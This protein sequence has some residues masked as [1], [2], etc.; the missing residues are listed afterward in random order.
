MN[1][2][3]FSVFLCIILILG[4]IVSIGAEGNFTNH[5]SE[6]NPVNSS[7]QE[8]DQDHSE[9]IQENSQRINEDVKYIQLE[10][11]IEENIS[12]NF[13]KS[14]S[15]PPK[16]NS[17]VLKENESQKTGQEVKEES[18]ESSNESLNYSLNE[19]NISGQK[20]A[21][22]FSSTSVEEIS[23]IHS[24][25]RGN[26]QKEAGADSSSASVSSSFEEDYVSLEGIETK[27]PTKTLSGEN[28]T[29]EKT[30]YNYYNEGKKVIEIETY[31]RVDIQKQEIEKSESEKQIIISSEEHIDDPLRIYVDLS[32]EAKKEEIEIY[33][34]NEGNLEI[35]SQE[36]FKVEYYD[37]D[38]NGLID[39]I[40]WI[41]PHLSEQTFK[42]II[43]LEKIPESSD[44]I[45]LNVNAPSFSGS[46]NNPIFFNASVNYS[47]DVNC[48]L[49]INE[50]SP[51]EFSGNLSNYS[52]NLPNGT[53][54]WIINCSDISN[55]SIYS[56]GSGN[57]TVNEGF[58]VSDP[59][60][61][62]L[63]NQNNYL[64][65]SLGVVQISSQ[66]NSNIEISIKRPSPH[67]DYKINLFGNSYN[68][69]LNES[70][71]L[72]P[73][74][75]T[76]KVNFK[77]PSAN[78]TI[79]KNFS[80]AK[81]E[82]LFND[83]EYGIGENVEINAKI[84]SPL[85]TI[86]FYALNFGDGTSD[87]LSFPSNPLNK[88]MYKSYNQAGIYIIKLETIID[89]KNFTIQKNGIT[90]IDRGDNS[91]PD[92]SLIYP[93]HNSVIANNTIVFEY[94]AKDNFKIQN[95]TFRL[96]NVTGSSEVEFTNVRETKT[97]LKNDENVKIT[98]T[99]FDEGE[100][101]W[102]VECFDNSSNSDYD[103]NLFKVK[104]SN[105]T[106][107]VGS[108]SNL[109]SGET[110][111]SQ[112]EVED[113]MTWI[114]EFLLNENNLGIKE[115]EALESM[116]IFNEVEYYKKR[117][118]QIDQYF[119]ENYKYVSDENLR[120]QKNEEYWEEFE[121]IKNSI[122]LNVEVLDDYEYVKNSIDSDL[123][124]VVSD[125]LKSTNTVASKGVIKTLA[126]MNL[127]LQQEISVSV[128]V[129]EI[130]IEYENNTQDLILVV[131]KIDL[132]DEDY[133]QILEVIPKEI[134]KNVNE[135]NFLVDKQVIKEDP[136]VEINYDDLNENKEIV[137]YFEKPLDIKKISKTET[138]LFEDSFQVKR[139]LTGFFAFDIP[140]GNPIYFALALL[141]A[142]C[143]II[144]FLFA[145]RKMRRQNWKREPNVAKVFD[146]L[147]QIN[148]YISEKD[149]E[150][151][152]EGYHEL[153]KVYPV[154]P[155]K[156]KTYFY[157][158]ISEVLVEIDKRDIFGL[159]REYEEA[160]RH[161]NKE[162]C[163]RIYKDIKKVYERLPDKYRKKIYERITRY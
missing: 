41:I 163:I 154:L 162:D 139:G 20:E 96:Y 32:K 117:L 6:R 123:E 112:Y 122:P 127:E 54:N 39:R 115:K 68:L 109:N 56:S 106:S 62:Y 74:Q 121:N 13:Q 99:D 93:S 100:Y 12:Q 72:V 14:E 140:D 151:A 44:Q 51:Q 89:G 53:Y 48:Y 149:L 83:G 79:E 144:L 84:N 43:N 91:D 1:K 119:K 47:G 101:E 66:K 27:T 4:F 42:I 150:R 104:Y 124:E 31:K 138:I 73:G 7:V 146:L 45:I 133:D 157:K 107:S 46:I 158:R 17:I 40:S 38:E 28:E 26:T 23:E 64:I 126:K 153:K 145:F 156:T 143:V 55:S 120:E 70:V 77:E 35:T 80:V 142:I 97:N 18:Y 159:V 37:E 50:F 136:V 125:Y 8:K 21:N 135:I 155:E 24:D 11:I 110:Y 86:S 95:C 147:G 129:K 34:E 137:Y 134:A 94:S 33:W 81:A 75:Y 92:I 88:V 10:Q 30:L 118:V 113:V 116:G 128:K 76:I 16:N 111:E 131:K 71:L 65:G 161:W 152:R 2:R 87:F 63:L 3:I 98:L 105:S 29:P 160:K 130:R 19:S 49:K 148:R 132:K 61:V 9:T 103:F 85:E 60:K 108:S 57:F 58:S 36:S 78:Y 90:I 141:L 59:D 82:L 22:N 69:V 114:N 5:D 67:E 102:E 25:V 52:L 15:T